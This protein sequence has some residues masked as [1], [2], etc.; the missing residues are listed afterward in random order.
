MDLQPTP[1]KRPVYSLLSK[2]KVK[3]SFSYVVPRWQYSLNDFIK[4]LSD[5][6]SR[7]SN[8]IEHA[9]YDLETAISSAP[10]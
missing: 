3:K 1:A 8:W 4:A 9:D 10:S 5:L 6:N 2:E 7:V